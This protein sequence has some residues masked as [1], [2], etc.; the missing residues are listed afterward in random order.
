MARIMINHVPHHQDSSDSHAINHINQIKLTTYSGV[1]KPR[2][3]TKLM[4]FLDLYSFCRCII[5]ASQDRFISLSPTASGILS[6]PIGGRRV[7]VQVTIDWYA[8][9]HR[10]DTG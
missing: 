10:F 7:L 4:S 3:L 8:K 1:R 9:C 6:N 2:F 5:K